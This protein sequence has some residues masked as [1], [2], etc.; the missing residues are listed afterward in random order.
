MKRKNFWCLSR[1]AVLCVFP[2]LVNAQ[3]S[4][5]T[6]K[7]VNTNDKDTFFALAANIKS[8][9]VP[10][11]RY[12]YIRPRE[13]E[14]VDLRLNDMQVLFNEFGTVEKMDQGS[15]VRLFSDQE[16]VN[17]TLTR[18]DDTRLVCQHE[19]PL[20]SHIPRT[21]CHPYKEVEQANAETHQEL[22]KAQ[23]INNLRGSGG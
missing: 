15:K 21:V 19:A 16:A 1:L 23:T 13:Q 8:Q 3:D 18:R 11:G 22:R 5:K 10:G 9:M 4:F 6:E 14:D 7:I 20:G 17:A 12:E 2:V